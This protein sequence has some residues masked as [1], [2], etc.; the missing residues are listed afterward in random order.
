M[1]LLDLLNILAARSFPAIMAVGVSSSLPLQTSPIEKILET[2][3]ASL[4]EAIILPL[5]AS[6]TPRF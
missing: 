2:D 6:F 5:G 4:S 1:I 3:V